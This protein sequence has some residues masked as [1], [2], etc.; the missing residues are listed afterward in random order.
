MTVLEEDS[1]LSLC[2]EQWSKQEATVAC[3]ELGYLQLEGFAGEC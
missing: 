1:W 2:S 3:R